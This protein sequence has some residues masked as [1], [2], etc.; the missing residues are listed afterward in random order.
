M[1]HNM[2]PEVHAEAVSPSE[3]WFDTFIQN[4]VELVRVHQLQLETNTA[5]P[6]LSQF[7]S[8]LSSDNIED[9]L[10]WNRDHGKKYFVERIVLDF[11]NQLKDGKVPNKLALSYNDS[12]VLVW[13]EIDDNDDASW[14]H[15]IQSAAIVNAK[16]HNYGYDIKTMVVEMSDNL[17]VPYHYK[18]LNLSSIN[19]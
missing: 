2:S 4:I 3:I 17:P 13:A 1:I 12:E 14:D 11:I 10:K 7:Y 6:E 16:Y 5:H 9:M 15:I 18:T 8:S 19:G